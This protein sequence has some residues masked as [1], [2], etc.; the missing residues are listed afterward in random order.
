MIKILL[1]A[2]VMGGLIQGSLIMFKPEPRYVVVE[3]FMGWDRPYIVWEEHY[4]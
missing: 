1:L 3:S 2:I 4:D